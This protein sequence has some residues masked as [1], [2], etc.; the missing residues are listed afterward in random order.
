MGCYLV[1]GSQP[2]GANLRF[3]NLSCY[4]RKQRGRWR[5][6]KEVLP[7]TVSCL[8]SLPWVTPL[9]A[10]FGSSRSHALGLWQGSV[11]LNW[12]CSTLI[13]LQ[14]TVS[15]RSVGPHLLWNLQPPANSLPSQSPS[16]FSLSLLDRPLASFFISLLC[17]VCGRAG[18]T[19]AIE[20][21]LLSEM[22]KKGFLR[23]Q[24]E[25]DI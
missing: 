14:D 11:A 7:V 15:E 17:I 20:K 24:T 13:P 10:C 19:M 6:P 16:S 1:C 12:R 18:S 3:I 9:Q 2:A 8:H 25:S 5:L 4:P 23:E 21:L 22:E